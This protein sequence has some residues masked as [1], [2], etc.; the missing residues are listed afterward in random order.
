MAGKAPA[1]DGEAIPTKAKADGAG[2]TQRPSSVVPEASQTPAPAHPAPEKNTANA[3]AGV[4]GLGAAAPQSHPPVRLHDANAADNEYNLKNYPD[5]DTLAKHG[6]VRDK[7]HR[8]YFTWVDAENNL[9]SSFYQPPPFK[10]KTLP[11]GGSSLDGVAFNRASVLAYR[12]AKPVDLPKDAAPGVSRVLGLNRPPQFLASFSESCCN[13]LQKGDI[14]DLPPDRDFLVKVEDSDPVFDFSSGKSYYRWVK[15]P[16]SRLP[17]ALRVK[18][19]IHNGVF[20]PTLVFFDSQFHI[21]RLITDISFDYA[22]ERWYRYGYLQATFP[23]YPA[24]HGGDRWLLVMTRKRDLHQKTIVDHENGIPP[25]QH[26][27]TGSLELA[28]V[29]KP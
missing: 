17:Y 3:K 10:E 22:P 7:S 16:D 5:G 28:V 23:V 2:A 8:P 19:F 18:S 29:G 1:S 27:P 11:K 13:T 14:A 12:P 9:R 4:G 24:G 25:I 26:T 21:T 6:F 20:V 15:L